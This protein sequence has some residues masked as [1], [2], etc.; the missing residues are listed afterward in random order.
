[1]LDGRMSEWMKTSVTELI[2]LV[3][4]PDSLD[5]FK[6]DTYKFNVF[7]KMKNWKLMKQ[8]IFSEALTNLNFELLYFTSA[9]SLVSNKNGRQRAAGITLCSLY[10]E[11]SNCG[12]THHP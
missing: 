2:T 7:N 10:C 8:N 11:E 5:T 3:G 9:L 6:N 4:L 1:M 12:K